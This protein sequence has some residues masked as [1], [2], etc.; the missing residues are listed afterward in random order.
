MGNVSLSVTSESAE[1]LVREAGGRARIGEVHGETG[2]C[3]LTGA[4]LRQTTNSD[5]FK[6]MITSA[7]VDIADVNYRSFLAETLKR[8]QK[9][10]SKMNSTFGMEQIDKFKVRGSDGWSASDSYKHYTAF[11][12]EHN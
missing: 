11:M 5:I 7:I 6:G 2:E 3:S 1:R 8:N 10:S 4:T 12:I 9:I